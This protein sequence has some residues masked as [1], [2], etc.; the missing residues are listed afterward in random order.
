MLWPEWAEASNSLGVALVATGR[1]ERAVQAYDR[2]LA[3]QRT[4]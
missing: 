2:A 3:V 4:N 1:I